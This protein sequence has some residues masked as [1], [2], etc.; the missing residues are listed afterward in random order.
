MKICLQIFWGIKEEIYLTKIK[1]LNYHSKNVLEIAMPN[2][3]L[4]FKGMSP[5]IIS[6]AN[7][8]SRELLK[9][10]QES[11]YLGVMID[12]SSDCSGKEILLLY[13]R[14]YS[15]EEQ[16]VKEVFVSLF[17]LEKLTAKA[18]YETFK[19]WLVKNKLF[20]KVIFFCSDAASNVS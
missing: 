17:E 11:S 5:I 3:H 6:I 12:E 8:I 20:E 7:C 19:P 16:K 14:F 10:I 13:I 4:S 2:N 18:I 15:K 9:I 1:S